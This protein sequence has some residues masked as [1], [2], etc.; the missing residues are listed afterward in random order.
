MGLRTRVFT[1]SILLSAMVINC[2]FCDIPCLDAI[3][4]NTETFISPL[5]DIVDANTLNQAFVDSNKAK[6]YGLVAGNVLVHCVGSSDLNT[7]AD[8]NFVVIPFTMNDQKYDLTINTTQ[9]FN[10]IEIPTELLVVNNRTKTPGD[11][12]KKS[13]MPKNYFFSDKCSDHHVRFNLDNKAAVN[14]AG[15]AAFAAYGGSENEFFL[16]MPV[17]KSCRAFPGLVLGDF[18]GWGAAEKIV[19]YKNY[20][21]G[22]KALKLFAA[23]LQNSSC[24][25]QGLAVYQV[26]INNQIVEKNGKKGWAIAAG[27]VGTPMMYLGVTAGLYALGVG[28]GSTGAAAMAVF[29]GALGAATV[30]VVGWIVAGVAVATAATIAFLPKDLADVEQVVVLS[31]PEIIR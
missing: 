11:V 10:Y 5:K 27:I 28:V 15:Q 31:E 18:G 3:G 25:N 26:S 17:G 29:S 9:L 12:I 6:L 22:R 1:F 21:E 7:I 13:D 14:K 23:K 16:D 30:P 4:G 20:Q 8:S 19:S 2:G 24:G